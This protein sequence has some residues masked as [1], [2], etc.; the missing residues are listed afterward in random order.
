MDHVQSSDTERLV[1]EFC[2]DY[3]FPGDEF[4]HKLTVL[5]GSG[6]LSGAEMSTAVPMKGTSGKFSIVQI[7]EFMQ[8]NGDADN[9]VIGKSDQETSIQVLIKDLL[10]ERGDG[11]RAWRNRK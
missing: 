1:S 7:L 2:L 10:R 8:G 5:S 11:R 4:G 3:C 6:R 9:R